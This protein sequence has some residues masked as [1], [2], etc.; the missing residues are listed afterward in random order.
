MGRMPASRAART[1]YNAADALH[2]GLSLDVMAERAGVDRRLTWLLE[3]LEWRSRLRFG[4]G[5]SWQPRERRRALLESWPGRAVRPRVEALV[6]RAQS[7]A[8][9]A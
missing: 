5:F 4:R 6:A 9:G 2:P 1:L 8:E 7:R 3:A